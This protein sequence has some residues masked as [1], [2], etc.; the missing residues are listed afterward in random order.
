MIIY[1]VENSIL[2]V[3]IEISFGCKFGDLVLEDLF[4]EVCTGK[5]NE[6]CQVGL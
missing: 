6:L 2:S 1:F 3:K 4:Q 5:M